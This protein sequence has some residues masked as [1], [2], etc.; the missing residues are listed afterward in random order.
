MS[1]ML[2]RP[3]WSDDARSMTG[4]GASPTMCAVV[5]LDLA[6]VRLRVVFFAD[7]FF[8][9]DFFV[10]LLRFAA[11]FS[12]SAILP[13]IEV[14]KTGI[15]LFSAV[16]RK[17]GHCERSHCAVRGGA[18]R[19]PHRSPCES[20]FAGFF[21]SDSEPFHPAVSYPRALPVDAVRSI[22]A[23]VRWKSA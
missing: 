4:A 19:F 8:T 7:A 20:R 16:F 5:A 2:M 18:G 1:M 10:V 3:N 22:G 13:I 23:R 15:P 17:C 9:D 14:G 6:L 21:L 11:L 12:S